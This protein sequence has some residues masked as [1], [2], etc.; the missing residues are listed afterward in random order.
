MY[1]LDAGDVAAV[2]VVAAVPMVLPPVQRCEFAADDGILVEH[3]TMVGLQRRRIPHQQPLHRRLPKKSS[4]NVPR[5]VRL[6]PLRV[7]AAHRLRR[8]RLSR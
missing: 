7:Y 1:S 6:R 2:A 5:E 4:S 8:K 3:P